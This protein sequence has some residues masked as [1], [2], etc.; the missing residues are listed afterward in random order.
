MQ[1]KKIIIFGSDGFI[2]KNLKNH[3]ENSINPTQNPNNEYIFLTREKIDLTNRESLK[4]YMQWKRPDIVIN[5]A[6]NIG[7]S[8]SN[9]VKNEYTIFK[10]NVIILMN[11]IQ[12]CEESNV[13]KL[14]LFST[15]RLFDNEVRENYDETDIGKGSV[16]NNRGYL[17]SKKVQNVLM[18]LAMKHSSTKIVCLII[19]NVFGE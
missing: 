10:E 17:E 3:F 9:K 2:G 18:E 4:N 14:L 8:L 7:S 12:C 6:G 1:H 19:T 5:A 15:Y 16:Q 11:L 13:E